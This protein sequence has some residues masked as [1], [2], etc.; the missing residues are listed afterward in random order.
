[1]LEYTR[2][3]RSGNFE[4]VIEDDIVS[5]DDGEG[6]STPTIFTPLDKGQLY[7]LRKGECSQEFDLV[8]AS[9]HSFQELKSHTCGVK[10]SN[11]SGSA[12]FAYPKAE[13]YTSHCIAVE[14]EITSRC[15]PMLVE[16]V[17]S[18][19]LQKLG[20][21]TVASDVI[22]ALSFCTTTTFQ[23]ESTTNGAALPSASTSEQMSITHPV[24]WFLSSIQLQGYAGQF[25]Y[26]HG[27]R[28]MQELV[29]RIRCEK[30]A[31][32]ILGEHASRQHQITLWKGLK[33]WVRRMENEAKREGKGKKAK[34]I[35]NGRPFAHDNID[36]GESLAPRSVKLPRTENA[37]QV[38]LGFTQEPC[39]VEANSGKFTELS[40][41]QLCDT[42]LWGGHTDPN[43]I[44]KFGKASDGVCPSGVREGGAFDILP[45]SLN[46]C[47]LGASV[48]AA[49]ESTSAGLSISRGK[50]LEYHGDLDSECSGSGRVGTHR[51][52]LLHP[53]RTL[54]SNTTP[55]EAIDVDAEDLVE[56]EASS[57]HAQVSADVIAAKQAS[58]ALL[59]TELWGA[60]GPWSHLKHPNPCYSDTALCP[61]EPTS[62][63]GVFCRSGGGEQVEGVKPSPDTVYPEQRDELV[64][65]NSDG[66]DSDWG[67]LAQSLQDDRMRLSSAV[68]YRDPIE[69]HQ[70]DSGCGESRGAASASEQNPLSSKGLILLD[71]QRSV[72]LSDL[73]NCGQSSLLCTDES[74][75]YSAEEAGPDAHWGAI[76]NSNHIEHWDDVVPHSYRCVKSA[77]PVALDNGHSMLSKNSSPSTR[78]CIKEEER[79]DVAK[80]DLQITASQRVIRYGNSIVSVDSGK[81]SSVNE[82]S[83]VQGA[84]EAIEGETSPTVKLLQHRVDK[85][86]SEGLQTHARLDDPQ[87]P[88][89]ALKL[90]GSMG[91]IERSAVSDDVTMQHIQTNFSS[92]SLADRSCVCVCSEYDVEGECAFDDFLPLGSQ[93][94]KLRERLNE[95]VT[96][97][98]DD[99]ME[100]NIRMELY[101][102]RWDP[103]T[104][105]K[106]PAPVIKEMTGKHILSH[107]TPLGIEYAY[108]QSGSRCLAG[109][110]MLL[111][112]CTYSSVNDLPNTESFTS[113]EAVELIPLSKKGVQKPTKMSLNTSST[114][115]TA[116]FRVKGDKSLKS[117]ETHI[118]E[119]HER[120]SEEGEQAATEASEED[121]WQQFGLQAI[122]S[123]MDVAHTGPLVHPFV[124]EFPMRSEISPSATPIRIKQT[125]A[126]SRCCGEC[127][128]DNTPRD[129]VDVTVIS[130]SEPR[131]ESGERL[132]RSD[133]QRKVPH[134]VREENVQSSLSMPSQ[135]PITG[136]SALC[137]GDPASSSSLC[138][139]SEESGGAGSTT[140]A[141]QELVAAYRIDPSLAQLTLFDLRVWCRRLGLRQDVR[142]FDSVE[143]NLS[144]SFFPPCLRCSSSLGHAQGNSEMP[145]DK[146]PELTRNDG[147]NETRA[148]LIH[149]EMIEA[150]E[151]RARLRLLAVRSYFYH[152]VAPECLHRVER[153]SGLPY[154]PLRA[155]DLIAQQE[156]Y[157]LT[158]KDLEYA[159]QRAKEILQEENER[160]I[161][162]SLA[163]H[164]VM[165]LEKR[166]FEHAKPRNGGEPG[167]CD[168]GLSVP[169]SSY[170]D[171]DPCA[172]ENLDDLCLF[173][174]ALILE[175]VDL[176]AMTVVVQ[177]DFPFISHS[178][179]QQMLTECDVPLQAVHQP[180]YARL[181]SSEL[182]APICN[183]AFHISE[184]SCSQVL[185]NEDSKKRMN[186]NG[187]DGSSLFAAPPAANFSVPFTLS[188][189]IVNTTPP[190][191]LNALS[192]ASP[193]PLQAS[194][195]RTRRENA[196]RFF[197]SRG[198]WRGRAG[199]YVRR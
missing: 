69:P 145:E 81:F 68:P 162:A 169:I 91:N 101:P 171:P 89:A 195:T 92:I 77:T 86:T 4:N 94:N 45:C 185:H 61:V 35:P 111:C 147:S 114:E 67:R 56:K 170:F 146:R 158:H 178:R 166:M 136:P 62:H 113:T 155:S 199:V 134:C 127:L 157:L 186:E 132:E 55:A 154:K 184:Q 54:P 102:A 14:G 152:T 83:S 36:S 9:S 194:Q 50:W 44:T 126:I 97:S 160:C 3:I 165:C 10:N 142:L 129:A 175:P 179:V 64:E 47:R 22:G 151:L 156:R 41:T 66:A 137:G 141:L 133:D 106:L 49:D 121:C 98:K 188:Q 48:A 104:N 42:L 80:I 28:S 167:L 25:I 124:E 82:V 72:L 177:R 51:G 34:R 6:T 196:R 52:T 19:S 2:R 74:D 30:D 172:V 109:S 164:A 115:G 20:I 181:A 32:A 108:E 12:T 99:A 39:A 16:N 189:S 59:N 31:K 100:Q 190:L 139:G 11:F 53:Q 128:Q 88:Q 143:E 120:N 23:Q 95:Y 8:S 38:R 85:S 174:R 150:D 193:T 21:S 17:G 13:T 105:H 71:A 7:V 110:P 168:R 58:R 79:D 148:A 78:V 57:A 144:M 130:D 5:N 140:L 46:A 107:Y 73:V 75:V 26:A 197:A 96:N 163:G 198:R 33:K 159:R 84:E 90:S 173:E 24:I 180:A 112:D 117:K 76:G 161:V 93:V 103:P 27:I 135:E 18:A 123:M 60:A 122:E 153:I 65:A 192:P 70:L 119:F 131:V 87:R 183:P 118:L 37:G 116:C 182:H 138:G 187:K 176:E 15:V 1:M 125:S 191:E 40:L 29:E 43:R 63:F 149:R